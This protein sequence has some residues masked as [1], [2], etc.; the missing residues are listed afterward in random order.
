M[1][2]YPLWKYLLLAMVLL[3]A[4]TYALPNLYGEDPAVQISLSERGTMPSDTPA[5]ITTLLEQQ[6]IAYKSVAQEGDKLLARFHNTADQLVGMEA[7]RQKLGNGYITALNLAQTTP[8]WLRSLGGEP[9]YLGLDLRGGVHFLMEVDMDAATVKAEERYVSDLRVILRKEKIRYKRISRNADGGV[10]LNFSDAAV[11]EAAKGRIGKEYPR[12]LIS[13]PDNLQLLLNISEKEIDE[14]RKFALQ[15][16]IT[17]LRNRVNE[18]GVAEPVIQ[19]QGKNRI[20]VQLPGVQDT[21]RAKE[22]IGATATLEFRLLSEGNDPY[23]AASSGRVPA[24]A[25]L[26]KERDGSPVLLKRRVLLTG[27]SIIDASSGIEQQSGSAAV[28]IT[29]DGKGARRMSNGTRDNIGKRMAVVFIESKSET[30]V[31]GKERVKVRKTKQE[32]INVAVIR[33]Q[34]GKRFQVTGLDSTEEAR[35]LALLLRAGALAIPMEIVEERTVGPSLGQDNIDKGFLSVAIGFLMVLVFM[36]LYYR[37]FG[38]VANMA[39]T[40]NLVLIVAVLS[41][42]QATLT[43]PGI[44]GIVLTVGMAVDANV[45]I[46]ERIREELRNGNSP[47]ASIHAGYDKAFSTITDA[48]VTTLIAAIV[49]FA[50]GT[51]PIKGFAVTL[52][53]GIVTSMFTAIMGTRAVIN[54]IYGGRKV[55]KLSI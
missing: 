29:L 23:E 7:I 4:A 12:L 41:M 2:Q 33:D 10:R 49:L 50:F 48:N 40:L 13:E 31:R 55:E 18:L 28:F 27:E 34:L 20:V 43:L 22:I 25:L 11:R 54:M 35:D 5:R 14:T 1:N 52:S 15:Q 37:V 47:Q 51:G 9:M 36:A 16:N 24:G 42:M 45:L 39:L 26:Y 38:L 46:F 21:A 17:T 8:A 30:E 19:Q 32:V 44:A 53:I 3:L 6:S